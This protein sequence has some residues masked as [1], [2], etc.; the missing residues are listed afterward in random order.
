MA[1]ALRAW[2]LSDIVRVEGCGWSREGVGGVVRAW[3]EATMMAR[4]REVCVCGLVVA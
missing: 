2:A 4:L 3:L 1:S